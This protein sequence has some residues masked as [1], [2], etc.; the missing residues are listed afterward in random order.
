M[1][2]GEAVLVEPISVKAVGRIGATL[3]SQRFMS[4]EAEFSRA[5]FGGGPVGGTDSV[6]FSLT[7]TLVDAFTLKRNAPFTNFRFLEV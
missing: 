7:S 6:Y 4:F 3:L 1:V 5:L 2:D